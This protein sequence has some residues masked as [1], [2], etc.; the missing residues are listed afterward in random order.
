MQL[1]T[2]FQLFAM[3]HEN[4]PTLKS[5]QTLLMMPDLFNLWLTGRKANE[6][7]DATTTQCYNPREKRWAFELLEALDIPQH[8]LGQIVP[9][10]TVLEELL[11]SVA[12]DAS[13]KRIPVIAV[14]SHDT[15][16]AVAAVPAESR[17]DLF[18]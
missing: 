15:A 14:G 10:G 3:R 17:E 11:P 13:C 1:N 8:V 7:T 6:F 4:D 12:E 9:S 18:L 16:S 5:A 2:L